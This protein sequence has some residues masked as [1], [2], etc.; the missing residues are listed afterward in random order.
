M[1][2]IYDIYVCVLAVPQKVC[3]RAYLMR[4]HLLMAAIT[5]A[6]VEP[7]HGA[8]AYVGCKVTS[9]WGLQLDNVVQQL[10]G[11]PG[12]SSRHCSALWA[13]R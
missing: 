3:G 5:Y 8:V 13:G 6:S 11:F 10:R 1:A 12:T 4:I 2:V 7:L 9:T